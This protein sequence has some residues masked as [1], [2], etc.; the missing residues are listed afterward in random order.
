MKFQ[1][2]VSFVSY[3]KDGEDHVWVSPVSKTLVG[4][5]ASLSWRGNFFVPQVGEFISP[6]AFAAWLLTG[7]EASRRD[8]MARIPKVHSLES[9]E[10][11]RQMLFLGKYHQLAAFKRLLVKNKELFNLRWVEYKLHSSGVKELHPDSERAQIIKAMATHVAENGANTPFSYSW[12]DR[13]EAFN[14]CMDFIKGVISQEQ[15]EEKQEQTTEQE[16][17]V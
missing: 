8:P 6:V 1:E 2:Y 11:V 16:E 9:K 13:Q 14:L 17:E 15:Q 3:K 10:F 7:N 5:V 12:F 4:K